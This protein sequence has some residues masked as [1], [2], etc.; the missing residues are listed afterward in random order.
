MAHNR[1][2][3]P[4]TQGGSRCQSV[5]NPPSS[6]HP[7]MEQNCGIKIGLTFWVKVNRQGM[8]FF[9]GIGL[10]FL[11]SLLGTGEHD[12][13]KK[14]S[15]EMHWKCYVH[16]IFK[17]SQKINKRL[18]KEDGVLRAHTRNLPNSVAAGL[19]FSS[20]FMSHFIILV[21]VIVIIVMLIINRHH[22]GFN[23]FA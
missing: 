17:N 10:A 2:M 14:W 1:N 3:R 15:H 9:W 4:C 23:F 11:F 8:T 6:K 22:H 12:L 7:K 13:N 19:L 21:V 20:P 5:K 18:K 16:R